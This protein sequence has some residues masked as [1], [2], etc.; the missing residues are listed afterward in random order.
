ME[1]KKLLEFMKKE[2]NCGDKMA[3]MIIQSLTMTG[4]ITPYFNRAHR[5]ELSND[6]ATAS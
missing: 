5:G 6:K 2:F 4:E 1:D 3:R